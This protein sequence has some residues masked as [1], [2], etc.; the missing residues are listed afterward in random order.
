MNTKTVQ[1][2]TEQDKWEP[3]D[4]GREAYKSYIDAPEQLILNESKDV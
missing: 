3:T 4:I 2:S 1:P